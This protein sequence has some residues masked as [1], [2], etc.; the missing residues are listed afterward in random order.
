MGWVLGAGQHEQEARTAVV[1]R[2]RR[3]RQAGVPSSQRPVV[4]RVARLL[5]S[6]CVAIRRA[7][8]PTGR[9]AA[10]SQA[11]AVQRG[12]ARSAACCVR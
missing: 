3:R 10:C 4:H 9:L 5:S 7:L 1:R 12:L 2:R 8:W 6:V 11:L